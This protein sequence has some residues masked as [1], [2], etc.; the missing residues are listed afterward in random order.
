MNLNKVEDSSSKLT[1]LFFFVYMQVLCIVCEC[2]FNKPPAFTISTHAHHRTH[3]RHIII[4]KSCGLFVNLHETWYWFWHTE[5]FFYGVCVLW[6]LLSWHA[7]SRVC[8]SSILVKISSLECFIFMVVYSSM[9]FL[10]YF[11]CFLWDFELSFG[12]KNCIYIFYIYISQ[13]C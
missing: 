9:F 3:K 5:L 12:V 2:V 11:V 10:V 4:I 13:T 6:I 8:I 1:P 7:Q